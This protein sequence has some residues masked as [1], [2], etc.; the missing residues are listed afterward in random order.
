MFWITKITDNNSNPEQHDDQCS[1]GFM[2]IEWFPHARYPNYF[3]SDGGSLMC[4]LATYPLWTVLAIY[5]SGY[6]DIVPRWRRVSLNLAAWWQQ[7]YFLL[8]SYPH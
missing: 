1:E 6:F 5:G 4:S 8:V 3:H 2:Q 7:T